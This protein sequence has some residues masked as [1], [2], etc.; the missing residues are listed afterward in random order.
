MLM[1]RSVST[2]LKHYIVELAVVSCRRQLQKR[3][4]WCCRPGY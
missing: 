1:T 3:N 2:S 4:F